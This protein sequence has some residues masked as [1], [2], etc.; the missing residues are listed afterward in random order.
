MKKTYKPIE[1]PSQHLKLAS[2][3]NKILNPN[4]LIIHSYTV[5]SL[6]EVMRKSYKSNCRQQKRI[7]E[8]CKMIEHMRRNEALYQEGQTELIRQL[9]ELEDEN[10]KLKKQFN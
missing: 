2:F 6:N 10:I 4:D 7:E 1:F 8:L 9:R 3:R 5:G